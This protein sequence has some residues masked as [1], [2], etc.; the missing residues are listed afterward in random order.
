MNQLN[1]SESGDWRKFLDP[2]KISRIANLKLVARLVVEG[3]IAG[4]HRSPY[5]GFSV[6]FA[7]HREYAKGDDPR[8]IDWKVWGRTDK[9]YIKEYEEETN[10]KACLILDG[11]ASM[12]YGAAEVTKLDYAR[13]VAAALGYLMIRQSDSVG[14]AVGADRMRRYIPPRSS[15]SH[16]TVLLKEMAR[17]PYPDAKE[18]TETSIASILH[19]IA[20]RMTRRG[21]IVILSDLWEEPLEVIRGLHHLR[22]RGHE[23][24]LFHILDSDEWE[25]PF[26][27]ATTFVDAETGEE[28]PTDA[29]LLRREYIQQAEEWR[30]YYTRE[31]SAARLDYIPVNT[32]V[33]FDHLLMRYLIRR[34]KMY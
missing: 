5:H 7:E 17:L 31:C 11:S 30:Q 21:L 23:V 32:S 15:P 14:L 6:E 13:S 33:P 19:T 16:L 4:L 3:F 28:L 24:I 22:Y 1:H 20:E 25:F 12:N 27:G 29:T 10:L 8:S 2:A 26:T 34:T 18:K 9:Y